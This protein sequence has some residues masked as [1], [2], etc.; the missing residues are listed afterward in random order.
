MIGGGALLGVGLIL[1]I[2]GIIVK[3]S[4]KKSVPAVRY[5]PSV[6]IQSG[7]I[8][9]PRNVVT[10]KKCG[11]ENNANGKFCIKCGGN[12]N[13]VPEEKPQEKPQED[14]ESLIVCPHCGG[15]L[16]RGN[17]FCQFCGKDIPDFL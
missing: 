13:E 17:K 1:L 10:C 4:K 12:L 9:M 11:A 2:V 5:N 15:I 16:K 6:E 14:E 3:A 7:T 8:E